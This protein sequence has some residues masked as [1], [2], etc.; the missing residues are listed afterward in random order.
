MTFTVFYAWQSDRPA[1]TN[2]LF[3]Q[4][5]LD[6][7]LAEIR[8]DTSLC[9]TP[10]LDHDSKEVPGTPSLADAIF[11]KIANCG[12][13]VADLTYVATTDAG[14]SVPNPNVL[15]ELG[16]AAHAIGWDRIVCVLNEAF[17]SANDLAFD[18]AHRRW[19]IRY[20]ARPG[21]ESDVASE[22]RDLAR[23]LEKGVRAIIASDRRTTTDRA[24]EFAF[25][26][27]KLREC[28]VS[29]EDAWRRNKRFDSLQQMWE[30]REGIAN[31]VQ[32]ALHESFA[33]RLCQP[34]HRVEDIDFGA[35]QTNFARRAYE[36]LQQ[37][38]NEISEAD[39]E[40]DFDLK[41]WETWRPREDPSAS[42]Q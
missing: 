27:G 13:F 24:S 29:A 10:I 16:F 26:K 21:N 11:E 9:D 5:A 42:D 41:K 12:V 19:P 35:D 33:R 8:A 1:E 15:L 32:E 4:Q 38:S 37:I 22:L 40:G 23:E 6:L 20:C 34:Y 30:W 7:A 2:R 17:G 14:K 18:L 31:F 36:I 39:V 3:I 28:E 25:V